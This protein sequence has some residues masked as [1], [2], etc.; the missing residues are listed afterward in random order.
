MTGTTEET[1]HFYD[2]PVHQPWY[3]V[4]MVSAFKRCLSKYA[5]FSGR[6]SRSEFWWMFLWNAIIYIILGGFMGAMMLMGAAPIMVMPFIGIVILY[7]LVSIVPAIA[8]GVRRLHDSN[9][10]GLWAFIPFLGT[11]AFAVPFFIG[12]LDTVLYFL[13]SPSQP[14]LS[15]TDIVTLV[16][17]SIG[18]FDCAVFGIVVFARKTRTEGERFD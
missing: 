14:A 7:F 13:G 17:G 4:S 6:A 12:F 2:P 10:P 1:L 5:T 16:I 3:G 9:L 18:T 15:V 8:L 11:A